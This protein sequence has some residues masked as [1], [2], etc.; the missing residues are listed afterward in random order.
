MK[1]T[2]L[3]LLPDSCDDTFWQDIAIYHVEANTV[4]IAQDKARREA[5]LETPDTKFNDWH[6]LAVFH[7]HHDNEVLN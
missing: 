7:G 6:V 2:V 1:F 5:M 3:L 4:L